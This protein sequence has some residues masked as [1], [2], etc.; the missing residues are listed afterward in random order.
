MSFVDSNGSDVAVDQIDTHELKIM[1]VA[2]AVYDA[3]AVGQPGLHLMT[4]NGVKCI[5]YGTALEWTLNVGDCT[6][7][8]KYAFWKTRPDPADVD[9]CLGLAVGGLAAG[10]VKRALTKNEWLEL[11]VEGAD[12]LG[13]SQRA[14]L[15]VS[16]VFQLQEV[17]S[18]P[19]ALSVNATERERAEWNE[20]QMLRWGVDSRW[21][22]QWTWADLS[23]AGSARCPI[24]GWLAYACEGVGRGEHQGRSGPLG[25]IVMRIM[26]DMQPLGSPK[27]AMGMDDDVAADALRMLRRGFAAAPREYAVALP[28]G[29]HRRQ[30]LMD[31]MR[32]ADPTTRQR[33]QAEL[34]DAR[35]AQV[36]PQWKGISA[37]VARE[38]ASARISALV[39]EMLE[40]MGLEG[41][42]TLSNVKALDDEL[43]DRYADS[44]RQP[45]MS[46]VPVDKRVRLVA[47]KMRAKAKPQ[48]PMVIQHSG[49]GSGAGTGGGGGGSGGSSAKGARE[50]ILRAAGKQRFLEIMADAK[51]L[52]DRGD[53]KGALQVM[54]TGK[55]DKH[56]QSR[57]DKLAVK[58]GWGVV[59][60]VDLD[61]DLRYSWLAQCITHGAEYL[62]HMVVQ[63]LVR[64]G[65]LEDEDVRQVQLEAL[66]AAAR[67]G[68]AKWE[69]VDFYS[70]LLLPVYE[71]VHGKVSQ[72]RATGERYTDLL[73]NLQLPKL[74]GAF[75]EAIG[76]RRTGDGSLRHAIES[77]NQTVALFGGRD[78]AATKELLRSQAEFVRSATRE[79]GA[80]YD[81]ERTSINYDEA[82]AP[83]ALRSAI[84]SPA[85]LQWGGIRR[86][87]REE[88]R[89][90]RF[91]HAGAKQPAAPRLPGCIE[92][93]CVKAAKPAKP[94]P[95]EKER[96]EPADKGGAAAQTEALQKFRDEQSARHKLGP[97]AATVNGDEILYAKRKYDKSRFPPGICHLYAIGMAD[98]RNAG[99]CPH[100][101]DCTLEHRELDWRKP[102]E[103]LRKMRTDIDASGEKR[104]RGEGGKGGG[105]GRGR[106]GAKRGRK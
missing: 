67:S 19:A 103:S 1:R 60:P 50:Q 34:F 25:K 80:A 70:M 36:A 49:S 87:H 62:G 39:G 81:V 14:G 31:E 95:L 99:L 61:P 47:E 68:G 9:R 28:A 16:A 102:E 75:A 57:P 26:S 64:D 12:A 15:K 40:A 33:W 45:G 85:R 92:F 66:W 11:L 27:V 79:I 78:E 6:D 21:V 104:P 89:R 54:F 82:W 22:R 20:R 2:P 73:L 52:H 71:A 63:Q 74:V 69:H 91:Q 35:A 38:T 72:A 90:T 88:A 100:E 105:R 46:V 86:S 76:M 51:V 42:P 18:A 65:D 37:A 23:A 56:P 59:E 13:L 93:A 94:T 77:S 30:A 24:G 4:V 3:A 48:A 17:P 106:G 10:R 5:E 7:I 41:G 55:S 96:P 53:H 44:L 97:R 29:P 101:K 58:C 83:P 43:L 98:G 8:G 84:D 32:C